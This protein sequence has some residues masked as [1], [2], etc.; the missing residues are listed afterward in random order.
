MEE[1]QDCGG[2]GVVGAHGHP[3]RKQR[4]MVT[5]SE[6]KQAP[7]RTEAEAELRPRAP[8]RLSCVWQQTPV[9]TG[10]AL[11]LSSSQPSD[12]EED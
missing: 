10:V 8:R 5:K 11:G 2:V 4:H 3:R 12:A 9:A 6:D 7:N 1:M